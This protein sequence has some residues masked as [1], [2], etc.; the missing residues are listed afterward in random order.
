MGRALAPIGPGEPL[1]GVPRSRLSRPRRA[2]WL[3]AVALAAACVPGCVGFRTAAGVGLTPK[4]GMVVSGHPRATRA[5]IDVLDSGG[6]A[7][8][9]VVAAALVLAVVDPRS[10]GLGGG[11]LAVWTAGDVAAAPLALDFL[12]AWPEELTK[13]AALPWANSRPVHGVPGS[14]YGLWLFHERLGRL[15]FRDVAAPAI[16]LARD[17]FPV[18]AALARQLEDEAVRER[19]SRA[20]VGRD[21][22]Y[23]SGRALAVGETL[24][25]AELAR[26]LERLV[27]SGPAGFYR[28]RVADALV[29]AVR[30]DGGV[31]EAGDLLAYA[32]TWREPLR[33]W[34]RG[35][36][37][38]TVPPPSTGGLVFLETL[39]LLD[40]FPLDEEIAVARREAERMG[41]ELAPGDPA[42]PTDVGLSGR[43]LHWW[44]EAL[45]QAARDR[46]TIAPLAPESVALDEVLAPQR[47][48]SRRVSIGETARAGEASA[49][50]GAGAD[51]PVTASVH[52]AVVDVDGNAVSLTLGLTSPFGSGLVAPGTGVLANDAAQRA[53]EPGARP[54][55]RSTMTPLLVRASGRGL[56]WALGAGGGLESVAAALQVFLRCEVYRQPLADAVAEP[57]LAPGAGVETRFEPGWDPL[58]LQA[59]EGRRHVVRDVPA[60]LGRVEAIRLG[61]DGEPAGAADPR[62]PGAVGV[63]DER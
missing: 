17:G 8:D 33:G 10:G 54:G 25:Q 6:N 7:A 51:E 48:A 27:A 20:G 45:R 1:V 52:L 15:P 31:L 44:I 41:R 3:I 19:L 56:R 43:A 21:L 9:A 57:R 29:A 12:S 63:Q 23:P 37:I 14:P 24:V 18:G 59:L 11:G 32:P 36:E 42:D 2:A 28:G 58:L 62:G 35:H 26:T 46:A 61:S 40:G 39:S 53:A 16:A 5:G 13:S 50:T 47:I 30:A 60:G 34:F 4:R 22:F 38:L 55:S 49:S